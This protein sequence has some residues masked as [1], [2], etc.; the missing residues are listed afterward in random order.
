[1]R[2]WACVCG[3]ELCA[4]IGWEPDVR[5]AGMLG[6]ARTLTSAKSPCG[7][8]A[9]PIGELNRALVP[10]P[11]LKPS[12]LPAS[13]VVSPVVGST[14][15]MRWFFQSWIATSVI[16]LSWEVWMRTAGLDAGS[17]T[18]RNEQKA[19]RVHSDTGWLVELGAGGVAV[20]EA[21]LAASERGC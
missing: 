17:G 6:Q 10:T 19:F 7:S 12:V 3:G 9:M 16:Q 11:S 21:C 18:H 14:F 4:C 8:I 13:V 20:F 2:A 15:R 1:M 5:G